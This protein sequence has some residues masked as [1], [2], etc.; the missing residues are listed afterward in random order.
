MILVTVQLQH[1]GFRVAVS[2]IETILH[3]YPISFK[4]AID[5]NPFI[6]MLSCN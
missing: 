3:G 6:V 4:T 1:T 2:H 5:D